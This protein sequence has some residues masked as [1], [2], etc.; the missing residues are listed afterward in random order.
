MLI[1]RVTDALMP[2]YTFRTEKVN[3]RDDRGGDVV[4]DVDP[5]LE[6]HDTNFYKEK[7]LI[8]ELGSLK[9]TLT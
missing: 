8:R 6:D 4:A 2:T 3:M 1:D 7:G 5:F 9:S